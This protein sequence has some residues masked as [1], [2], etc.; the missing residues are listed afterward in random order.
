[1]NK[2]KPYMGYSRALGSHES[3]VLIFAY[4]AVDARILGFRQMGEI[5]DGDY[6]DFAVRRLWKS[7]WMFKD[8]DQEKLKAGMP[9]VVVSPKGCR[10]CELWGEELNEQGYCSGCEGESK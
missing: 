4:T 1:M 5:V 10:S 6:L 2:L 7:N 3:A 8:A 9:H